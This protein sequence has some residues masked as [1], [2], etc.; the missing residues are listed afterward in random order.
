MDKIKIIFNPALE[1]LETEVNDFL[2]QE[3]I[4]NVKAVEILST[5]NARYCGYVCYVHYS[6]T[7]TKFLD[8]DVIPVELPEY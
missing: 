1:D 2:K 6:T 7:T 5:N 3:F 8:Q 4:T